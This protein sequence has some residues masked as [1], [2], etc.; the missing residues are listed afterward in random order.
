M[1]QMQIDENVRAS[2]A[3]VG[4]QRVQE[5]ARELSEYGLAIAVPHLH[6]GLR[7][8]PLPSDQ[9]QYEENQSISFIDR[10]EFEAQRTTAF[11]VMWKFEKTDGRVSPVAWCHQD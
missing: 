3:A 2:I 6:S 4:S 5:I 7:V 11:P 1:T 8:L 9:I 10:A